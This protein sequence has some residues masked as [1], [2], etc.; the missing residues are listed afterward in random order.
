[1]AGDNN[2]HIDARDL[3]RVI[4]T[5]KPPVIPHVIMISTE[6]FQCRTAEICGRV[7]DAFVATSEAAAQAG[8]NGR[9]RVLDG[10]HDL[11]VTNL[12][13]VVAA[14]DDVASAVQAR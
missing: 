5:A 13:D 9:L 6:R 7:Y 8:K 10:D 4:D 14:I 3:S 12:K 2:E 1:M 11:Y